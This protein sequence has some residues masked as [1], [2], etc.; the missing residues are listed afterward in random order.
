MGLYRLSNLNV[1]LYAQSINN[2]SLAF[3]GGLQLELT[4]LRN[5]VGFDLGINNSTF[6]QTYFN[7]FTYL[8]FDNWD[9]SFFHIVEQDLMLEGFL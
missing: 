1:D 6:S 9:H 7:F 4:N 5:D 8:K 2:Q 3:G